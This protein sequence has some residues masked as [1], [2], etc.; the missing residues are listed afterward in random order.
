MKSG[1]GGIFPTALSHALSLFDV[2]RERMIWG[3]PRDASS[4]PILLGLGRHPWRSGVL[5]FSKAERIGRRARVNR[6]VVR[7]WSNA[8]EGVLPRAQTIQLRSL[9]AKDVPIV[10]HA[11]GAYGDGIDGLLG[12]SFLSRFNIN[13]DGKTVRISPRTAR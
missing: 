1:R 12:M 13:I 6:R 3:L 8:A 4:A 11:G 2:S 10:V 7:T 5:L 9:V